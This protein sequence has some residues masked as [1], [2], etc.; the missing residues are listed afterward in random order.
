MLRNELVFNPRQR[1]PKLW[2]STNSCYMYHGYMEGMCWLA[3]AI[4]AQAWLGQLLQL[5][6]PWG[7]CDPCCIFSSHPPFLLSCT[8]VLQPCA[9]HVP[10]LG[11]VPGT[12]P[13]ITMSNVVRKYFTYPIVLSGEPATAQVL[14]FTVLLRRNMFCFT[15]IH[16]H[17]SWTPWMLFWRWAVMMRVKAVTPH[18]LYIEASIPYQPTSD[19][20]SCPS[21]SGRNHTQLMNILIFIYIYI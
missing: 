19:W 8:A 17:S 10:V 16:L 12:P 18:I 4:L 9:W 1:S 20:K 3:H 7:V 2:A 5:G 21:A 14:V 11:M 15:Y 6:I 13:Y